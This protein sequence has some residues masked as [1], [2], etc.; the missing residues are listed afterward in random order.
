MTYIIRKL[1]HTDLVFLVYDLRLVVIIRITLVNTQTD[2][3]VLLDCTISST[4]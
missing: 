2:R 4:S 3:Q 1:S